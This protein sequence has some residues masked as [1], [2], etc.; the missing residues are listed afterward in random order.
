MQKQQ[1]SIRHPGRARRGVLEKILAA[2][3]THNR[4]ARENAVAIPRGGR[5]AC[6]S[7]KAHGLATAEPE[8]FR[9]LHERLRKA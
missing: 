5:K 1:K 4:G 7:R 9:K 8:T 3:G 2:V 6:G